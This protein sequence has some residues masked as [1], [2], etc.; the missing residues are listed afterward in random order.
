MLTHTYIDS[1][2]QEC[3]AILQTSGTL[4]GH[5][6]EH[7]VFKHLPEGKLWPVDASWKLRS[8]PELL[9]ARAVVAEGHK[10]M[11]ALAQAVL[12]LTLPCLCST[13]SAAGNLSAR[14]LWPHLR[15]IYEAHCHTPV[16]LVC[17]PCSHSLILGHLFWQFN[18]GVCYGFS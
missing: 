3:P 4:L 6:P 5:L 14:V 8:F 9:S 17:V 15:V 1:P 7:A 13:I 12:T 18:E 10:Q 11:H 2:A 16:V